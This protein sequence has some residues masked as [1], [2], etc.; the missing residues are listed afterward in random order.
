[1]ALV[2]AVI[3]GAIAAI[4]IPYIDAAGS[5][6]MFEWLRYGV[7]HVTLAGRH[8]AWSW[9]V[10]CVVTLFTWALLAWANR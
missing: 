10:F 6:L 4:A 3:T 1:M 2:K 8:F 9:P 7:V 5:G